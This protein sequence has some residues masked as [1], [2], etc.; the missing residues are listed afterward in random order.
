MGILVPD[1]TIPMGL[2][3]SNVYMSFTGEQISIYPVLGS[4]IFIINTNYRIYKDSTKRHETNI[5]IAIQVETSNISSGV[6]VILY[7]KLKVLY[8]GSTDV[9]DPEIVPT[10]SSSN[11]LIIPPPARPDGMSE[12]QYT[13][14]TDLLSRVSVY[15]E[16]NPGNTELEDAYN[17]AENS[18][19]VML[20]SDTTTLT[21]LETLYNSLI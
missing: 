11:T 8:P 5:R 13:Y 17:S 6:Y 18:F 19:L 3:L 10:V 20:S 14:W 15:I 21:T 16:N 4:N 7:D 2:T 9:F 1:A 12:T